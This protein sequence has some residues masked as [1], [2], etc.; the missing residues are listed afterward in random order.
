MLIFSMKK[1]INKIV[2]AALKAAGLKYHVK[3]DI[4][5]NIGI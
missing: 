3:D 2:E 1:R 5:F 4:L